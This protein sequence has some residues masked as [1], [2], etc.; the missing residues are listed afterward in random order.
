MGRF[1]ACRLVVAIRKIF[2]CRI[3]D[4][5][6]RGVLIIM[7]SPFMS[8]RSLNDAAQTSGVPRS[9]LYGAIDLTI[10]VFSHQVS[11]IS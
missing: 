11:P 5:Y 1:Y 7:L 4:P 8:A 3:G 6:H 2:R 9:L 10:R